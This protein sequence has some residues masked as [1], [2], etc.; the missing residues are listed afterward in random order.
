MIKAIV[1]LLFGIAAHRCAPYYMRVITVGIFPSREEQVWKYFWPL[2]NRHSY[3]RIFL[4]AS[5]T[6]AIAAEELF[7]IERELYR[8]AVFVLIVVWALWVQID[9][10]RA[11]FSARRGG[12][13]L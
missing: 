10:I 6:I 8:N 7:Q 11:G 12:V 2:Y 9:I 13:Q 1:V 4:L 3:I 5:V